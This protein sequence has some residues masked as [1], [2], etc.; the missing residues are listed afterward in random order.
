M[1][2]INFSV[3]NVVL[4]TAK[5]VCLIILGLVTFSA[6]QG[7]DDVAYSK[8]G[9]IRVSTTIAPSWML[10]HKGLMNISMNSFLEV[11]A[12]NKISFIGGSI[13]YVGSQS[14]TPFLKYNHSA[15]FGAL[16]HF[17]NS[18][19]DPYIGLYQGFNIIKYVN[20]TS[21][22]LNPT[23]Y[24]STGFNYFMTDWIN[25]YVNATYNQNKLVDLKQNNNLNEVRLSVGLCFGL[26]AWNKQK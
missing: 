25:L 4:E 26:R 11:Y 21:T 10:A 6:A 5:K 8:K 3:R 12:E 1:V 7:Q 20:H 24:A 17:T 18:R 13:L 15:Y 16:Y 23:I 22:Y 9:L 14:K 2:R 19:F